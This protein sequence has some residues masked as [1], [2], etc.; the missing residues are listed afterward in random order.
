MTDKQEEAIEA[1][2]NAAK[3]YE[4]GKQWASVVTEM[5]SFTKRFAG[6]PEAAEYQVEAE[7]SIAQAYKKMGKNNDYEK[8][9]A[10]VITKYNM[11]KNNLK[12]GAMSIDH[13][14]EAKFILVEKGLPSVEKYKLNTN[15]EKKVAE[16]LKTLKDMRDNLI[17]QYVQVVNMASPE[18]SVAAQFRIG[19]LYETHSKII[20]DAPIPASVTKLGAEAEEM[21]RD[22]I[23]SIVTPLEDEA[24]VEYAKAMQLSKAAGVFTKWTELTLERLNAY[25]PDEYPIY[26]KGKT[27]KIKESYGAASFD[28]KK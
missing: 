22:K 28:T 24:K 12:P 4:K 17:A 6:A 1:L 19:Y 21:Y 26:I 7:W 18:W 25:S 27:K 8:A 13:A 20:L 15:N 14:A 23:M 9:L 11:V 16:N 2:W 3:G 5:R 10:D